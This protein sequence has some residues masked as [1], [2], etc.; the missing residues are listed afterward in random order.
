MKH[1]HYRYIS[2]MLFMQCILFLPSCKVTQ[3]SESV[4]R[5]AQRVSDSYAATMRPFIKTAV[6]YDQFISI[7]DFSA[8]LLTDEARM[9]YLDYF[10]HRTF[11]TEEEQLIARQRLLTEN[12]FYVTFYVVGY[13]Q[14]VL[15]TSGRALF[16]GEYQAQGSM[17][18]G[19]DA[20]WRTSMLVDGKEYTPAEIRLVEL[21]VEYR[22]FFGVNWSQFKFAYKIRFDRR[23]EN[24]KEILTSGKHHVSLKF[25]STI[26][27]VKLEW[28]DVPYR[29]PEMK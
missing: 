1:I 12:D 4:F 17:L 24:N 10:F 29:Y 2:I 18:G 16:S 26:Y 23:D 5:Q 21:P 25:S 8:L 11:K 15:Y 20:V 14:P 6:I 3:W 19:A 7:A 9:I 13:Q 28:I 27:D 22:H